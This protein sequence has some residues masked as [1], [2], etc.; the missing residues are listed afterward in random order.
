MMKHSAILASVALVGAL[1]TAT[2]AGVFDMPTSDSLSLTAFAVV[3]AI[4]A[5]LAGALTLRLSRRRSLGVQAAI[6]TLTAVVAVALGV[7]VAANAMFISSH[8]LRTLWVVLIPAGTIGGLI[9]LVLGRS[10][11]E[12][13]RSLASTARK[14]GD[15]D[16]A[17]AS[18][19]RATGEFATLALELEEMSARLEIARERERK[20]ETS[21]R[22]L[23]AWVSHDLRT[24]L[25][26]IRA[27]AEAL[28]DGVVADPV[29][30]ERYHHVMR[31]E[32]D[33]L[34]EL[35]DD[36]FELS[37]INSGTM[38]LEMERVSLGDLVSDALAAA[39]GVASVRGVHIEGRVAGQ[40]P[41]LELSASEISRVLRNL[42]ENAIRHTPTDGVVWVET[43]AD[44]SHAFVRVADTCGG[45]P[46]RDIDRVFDTAWRGAMARTPG[47]DGGAGLGL[48]IARGIVEAH[49]GDISVSN[50]GAGCR[51]TVR[52]PLRNG[53]LPA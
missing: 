22:E 8:D 26:G 19:H 28:E 45:I 40:P 46:E 32:V 49:N 42:L 34:A 47:D 52:L 3:T 31:L 9:A 36:L 18:P 51:F 10:V 16:F 41:E 50:E 17:S 6:S 38:R 37:R 30:V 43:G 21:R 11:A 23:V 25:S 48:A 4:A 15:G 12:S 33:R 53:P 2:V 14:I 1:A 39:S 27:M 24:P 13:S 35:V 5:G 7:V 20:L 29:T 44:S